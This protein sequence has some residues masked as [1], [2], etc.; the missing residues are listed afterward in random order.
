MPLDLRDEGA[1]LTHS[2]PARVRRIDSNDAHPG[3]PG[4]VLLPSQAGSD[5]AAAGQPA[6]HVCSV[7]PGPAGYGCGHVAQAD[8]NHWH[9]SGQEGRVELGGEGKGAEGRDG[10]TATGS[11]YCHVQKGRQDQACIGN[12]C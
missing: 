1:V 7:L 3:V 10:I 2:D 12:S 4:A 11:T 8:A 6:R 5:H 9:R